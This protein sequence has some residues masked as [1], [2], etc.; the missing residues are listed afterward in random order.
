MPVTNVSTFY[1]G[2]C[3]LYTKYIVQL[4]CVALSCFCL[5]CSEHT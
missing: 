4:T 1:A 5:F 3:R 2:N